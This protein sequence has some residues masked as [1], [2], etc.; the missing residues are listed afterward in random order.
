MP[1]PNLLWKFTPLFLGIPRKIL[2]IPK[3]IS[4]GQRFR[5]SPNTSQLSLPFFI[6]ISRFSGW[7]VFLS[8]HVSHHLK[9]I[10]NLWI[11]SFFSL[12]SLWLTEK[13]WF[14][15][16]FCISNSIIMLVDKWPKTRLQLTLIVHRKYLES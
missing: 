11:L 7:A 3:A 8:K 9:P 10:K 6:N 12:K 4:Q 15:N 1:S 16:E 14:Q 13:Y 2:G 5:E